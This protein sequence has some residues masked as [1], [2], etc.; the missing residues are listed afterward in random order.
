MAR[1]TKWNGKK[2]V[3]PQ[4]SWREITERLVAYENTG[5]EPEEIQTTVNP[6]AYTL[7]IISGDCYNKEVWFG[8]PS[9]LGARESELRKMSKDWGWGDAEIVVTPVKKMV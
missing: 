6:Q 1:L 9:E 2:W 5:L 4:N 8:F 7:E 3:L